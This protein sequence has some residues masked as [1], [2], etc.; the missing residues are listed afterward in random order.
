MRKED[1]IIYT[2]AV[3]VYLILLAINQTIFQLGTS[4]IGLLWLYAMLD[5]GRV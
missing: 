5:K 4:T 2:V 1:K 3:V